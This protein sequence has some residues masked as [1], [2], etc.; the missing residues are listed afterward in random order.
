MQAP[1]IFEPL[2]VAPIALAAEK[3]T[4]QRLAFV[5]LVSIKTGNYFHE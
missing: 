5:K 2:K 1:V 4:P 3:S